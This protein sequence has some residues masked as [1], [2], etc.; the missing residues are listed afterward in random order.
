MLTYAVLDGMNGVA[1]EGTEASGVWIRDRHAIR[2]SAERGVFID[3]GWAVRGSFGV[4][5]RR[6]RWRRDPP[7]QHGDGTTLSFADG[8]ADHWAWKGVDTIDL[9]RRREFGRPGEDHVPETIEGYEDLHRLQ[10]ATW[11]RLG[12]E[13]TE[14]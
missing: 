5:F 14:Y 2:E 13:P 10:R 12:Y 6:E 9:G 4:Y 8:H 3:D 11:G 7:V 1:R